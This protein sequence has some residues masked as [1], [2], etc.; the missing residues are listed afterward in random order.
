MHISLFLGTKPRLQC[1][2]FICPLRSL[3]LFLAQTVASW[4]K[5]AQIMSSYTLLDWGPLSLYVPS[6]NFKTCRFVYWGGTMLL[7]IFHLCLCAFLCHCHSFNPS[8]CRLLLFL[9][10]HVAVSRPCCLLKFTLPGPLDCT[11]SIFSRRR[12]VLIKISQYLP[13]KWVSKA[14][15]IMAIIWSFTLRWL[16]V[17]FMMFPKIN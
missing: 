3:H 4:P 6:L 2:F 10:P 17:Y 15:V 13:C 8:L 11:Y 9:L 16:C 7:S 5:W 14:T 1:P 12:T